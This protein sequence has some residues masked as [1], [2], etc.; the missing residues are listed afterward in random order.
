MTKT[1]KQKAARKKLDAS[2]LC[3]KDGRI[4]SVFVGPFAVLIDRKRAKVLYPDDNGVMQ[5]MRV[6][7]LRGDV[8]E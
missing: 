4:T 1:A 7:I 8:Q 6:K 3:N 2:V 5:V